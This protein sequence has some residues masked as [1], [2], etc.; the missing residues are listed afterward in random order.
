MAEIKFRNIKN[1]EDDKVGGLAFGNQGANSNALWLTP[2]DTTYTVIGNTTDK[3]I[4]YELVLDDYREDK[5]VQKIKE[6]EYKNY[7]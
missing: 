6:I 4:K 2:D 3:I 7:L 1:I 5:L